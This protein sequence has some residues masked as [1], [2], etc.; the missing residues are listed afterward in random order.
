MQSI[1]L[2]VTQNFV[3]SFIWPKTLAKTPTFS[4][5][6][7]HPSPPMEVP[8]STFL[9]SLPKSQRE[10][11]LF[12]MSRPRWDSSGVKFN[13]S[14]SSSS[15]TTKLFE[16]CAAAHYKYQ[17]SQREPI[18]EAQP[19]GGRMSRS[20]KLQSARDHETWSAADERAYVKAFGKPSGEF[21][22]EKPTGCA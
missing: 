4:L 22:E 7:A 21:V 20:Y 17:R 8:L 19:V 3:E 1:S 9:A 2:V 13:H 5:A 10:T 6:D 11:F 12:T 14:T 15:D 16:D 18:H